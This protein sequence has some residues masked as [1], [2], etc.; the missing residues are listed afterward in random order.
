MIVF[1]ESLSLPGLTEWLRLIFV[2]VSLDIPPCYILSTNSQYLNQITGFIAQLTLVLALQRETGGTIAILG[3]AQ[4]CPSACAR[5]LLYFIALI[6]KSGGHVSHCTMG[7]NRDSTQYR[8]IHWD[9]GDHDCWSMGGSEYP[10]VWS[11]CHLADTLKVEGET[12]GN[13]LG[14][15]AAQA[16]YCDVHY[17]THRRRRLDGGAY[18]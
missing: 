18:R 16:R 3:Y 10:L 8:S 13:E 15:R 9:V 11:I 1:G 4:V 2:S 14:D 6:V 5:C 12:R 17:G 7:N